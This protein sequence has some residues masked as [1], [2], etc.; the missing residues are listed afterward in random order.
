M[1]ISKAITLSVGLFLFFA[2]L[3]L[4]V[5]KPAYSGVPFSLGCCVSDGPEAECLGCGELGNCAITQQTCLVDL[6]GGFFQGGSAC[7]QEGDEPPGCFITGPSQGCC[8]DISGSCEDGV[9][10]SSCGGDQWFIGNRC[11]DIPQCRPPTPEIP[12]LSQWGIIALAAILGVV[13]F[14]V[15][16]RKRVTA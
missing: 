1:K 3:V 6:E 4:A 12:A 16:R 14:I 7:I 13:G 9:E 11:S 15:I 8:V 10:V 2:L 5:P